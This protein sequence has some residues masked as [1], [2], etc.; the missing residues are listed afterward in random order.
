MHLSVDIKAMS[1]YTG[2]LND[3]SLDI[4]ISKNGTRNSAEMRKIFEKFSSKSKEPTIIG[5]S[6]R[7][8]LVTVRNVPRISPV[9]SSFVE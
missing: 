9:C 5:D 7:A 6:R 1:S 2:S 3:R 4:V 8:I